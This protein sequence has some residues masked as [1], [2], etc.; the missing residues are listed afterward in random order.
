M[1]VVINYNSVSKIC[2]IKEQRKISKI[3]SRG[4]LSLMFQDVIS[5]NPYNY[6]CNCS[7]LII[8]RLRKRHNEWRSCNYF[9]S[10]KASN[11]KFMSVYL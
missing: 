2:F 4:P 3:C 6:D 10:P 5:Y 1:N 7:V 9:W 11:I 8:I